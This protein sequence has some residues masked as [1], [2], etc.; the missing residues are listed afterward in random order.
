MHLT[1]ALIACFTTALVIARQPLTIS[2]IVSLVAV[3]VTALLMISPL[4][5]I[6]SLI[7][8]T[9]AVFASTTVPL[10]KQHSIYSFK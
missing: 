10:V 1:D 9:Y 2:Y 4:T 7:A 5:D 8:I 3:W 6:A